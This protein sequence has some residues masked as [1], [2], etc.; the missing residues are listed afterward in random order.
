MASSDRQVVSVRVP[1]GEYSAAIFAF[2]FLAAFFLYIDLDIPALIILFLLVPVLAYCAWSDR[3][4]F[5]GRR[6]RRTGLIFRAWSRIWRFRASLTIASVEFVHTTSGRSFRR[7]GRI[8]YRYRTSFHG[9]GLRFSVV[10]TARGYKEMIRAVLPRLPQEV[11]DLQTME[12]RDYFREPNR[13]LADALQAGIPS[14]DVLEGSFRRI[15]L[16]VPRVSKF[17]QDGKSQSADAVATANLITLANELKVS[18]RLLQS[19]EA[20]RRALYMAPANPRTLFDL[21]RCL[22]AFAGIQRDR[23][24]ERRA[25]ALMRL[26]EKRAGD[27][28][29]LLTNLAESYYRIGDWRRAAIV[30]QRTVDKFGGNVRSLT[31]LAELALRDGRIAHVVHNFAAAAELAGSRSVRQRTRDEVEYFTRL[32]EDEEYMDLELSRINLLDTLQSTSSTAT[33]ITLCGFPVI[34]LGLLFGNP[35][36]ANTGWAVSGLALLVWLAAGVFSR[37]FVLRIPYEHLEED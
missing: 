4:C 3:I 29:D 34:G 20:F 26:A 6:L 1:S 7:G 23:R 27:D 12:I 37:M 32:N 8:L 33:W 9:R 21:S 19:L 25:E 10:S 28:R 13:V 30:F 15:R 24:L 2:S 14:A 17:E 18:G 11:L 36:V 5:D 31:G 35:S 16:E 22:R